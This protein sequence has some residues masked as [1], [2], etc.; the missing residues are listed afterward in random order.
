MF[1]IRSSKCRPQPRVNWDFSG[2]AFARSRCSIGSNDF[3]YKRQPLRLLQPQARLSLPFSPIPDA[4]CALPL[5]A[6]PGRERVPR[7]ARDDRGRGD[8][9]QE[10]AA[11]GAADGTQV[12]IP[13]QPL[14]PPRRGRRTQGAG[15]GASVLSARLPDQDARARAY[16]RFVD[17]LKIA[18]TQLQRDK[19]P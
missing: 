4:S 14:K 16:E 6:P 10:T 3:E 2:D 12:L 11:A 8:R 9:A 17:D 7:L 19:T 15:D 1:T 13:R 5:S 18:A